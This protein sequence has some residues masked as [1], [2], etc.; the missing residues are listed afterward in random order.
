MG[1]W[2]FSRV[3]VPEGQ[4]LNLKLHY[5]G[6]RHLLSIIPSAPHTSPVRKSLRP[7]FIDKHMGTHSRLPSQEQRPHDDWLPW[8]PQQGR[9]S[10]GCCEA[11]ST[12]SDWG[13]GPNAT[14][15]LV[16]RGPEPKSTQLACLLGKGSAQCLDSVGLSCLGNSFH[17]L[18]SV[19]TQAAVWFWGSSLLCPTITLIW[20]TG[21]W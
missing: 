15:L 16:S 1:C 7:R 10:K 17:H 5:S 6:P 2:C 18:S 9:G 20:E 19:R 11:L 14:T 21:G 3:R 4:A 13:P 12:R 8:P